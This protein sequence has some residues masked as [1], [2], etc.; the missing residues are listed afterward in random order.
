MVLAGD[1]LRVSG[2]R[3]IVAALD[4]RRHEVY[5]A[6]YRAA[7]GS[8]ER[9]SDYQLGTPAAVLDALSANDEH[10]AVCGDGALRFA[11]VF[12]ADPRVEVLGNAYAAPDLAAL[13]EIAI[14]RT[15][16]G[17]VVAPDAVVPL[18][19]RGSDAEI[20]QHERAAAAG[21]AA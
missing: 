4:A 5:W 8:I 9:Q 18:Y 21:G 6:R 19:L 7:A 12:A 14:V 3:S 20:T 10:V 11:E 16:A 15:T 2:E 1:P 17:D 13:V